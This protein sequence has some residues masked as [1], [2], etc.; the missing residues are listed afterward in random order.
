MTVEAAEDVEARAGGVH[1]EW[2]G[3]T[4]GGEGDVGACTVEPILLEG[5]EVQEGGD[6]GGPG[7]ERGM[8]MPPA[9]MSRSRA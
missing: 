3:S 9:G 4:R 1:R 5:T 6:A 2:R 8:G 7:A